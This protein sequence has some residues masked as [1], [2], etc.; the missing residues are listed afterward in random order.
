MQRP[1]GFQSFKDD[2]KITDDEFK[3]DVE[4]Y[5]RN[6]YHRNNRSCINFHFTFSY[7]AQNY[8]KSHNRHE[9][10]PVAVNLPALKTSENKY[11]R[12]TASTTIDPDVAII[13]N[14][15]RYYY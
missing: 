12:S 11:V 6:N 15:K 8:Q 3:A 4:K 7:S 2:V 10:A 1:E 13:R 14:V 9:S 5:S